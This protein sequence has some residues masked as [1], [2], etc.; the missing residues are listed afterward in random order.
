MAKKVVAQVKLQLPCGAATP[1][2]P[3]G[4]SLAPT[5]VNL[6]EFI[7]TFNA[8]TASQAGM[9]VGVVVTVYADRSFSMEIKSPPAPI[10]LKKAA[11]I[12]KGSGEPNKNKVGVITSAQLRQIAETKMRDL[13]AGDVEAAMRI[14]AG[15]ARSMGITIEG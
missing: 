12:D 8:Q 6:G 14:V 2:P 11:G 5:G 15:T 13:N 10:L 7:K 1:S 9:I 4:P 3:V